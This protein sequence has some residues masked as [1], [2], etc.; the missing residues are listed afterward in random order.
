MARFRYSMQNVLN[1][2]IKL[3][4]QAKIEFGN[5]MAYLDQCE[6]ELAML[7]IRKNNY[8]NEGRSLL[9]GSL[10]VRNLE[11]NK[12]ALEVIESYID[13]AKVKVASAERAV[14]T[15]RAHLTECMQER[16]VQ[17]NLREKA[18]Q[19]YLAEENMAEGKVT[20]ELTSYVYSAKR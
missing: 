13:A 8:I 15:A 16:K 17:E 5:A 18:F 11:E 19:Q 10:N 1:L 3:E 7:R 2:K 20:D 6:S 14:E 9:S 4:D 12:H